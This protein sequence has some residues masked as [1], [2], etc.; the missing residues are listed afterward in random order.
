METNQVE[1]AL[2]ILKYLPPLYNNE[3]SF[4]IDDLTNKDDDFQYL[5]LHNFQTYIYSSRPDIYVIMDKATDQSY[6]PV[7]FS[8]LRQYIIS[9]NAKL[10]PL[11]FH[12]GKSFFYVHNSQEIDFKKMFAIPLLDNL[13][14]AEYVKEMDQR[15]KQIQQDEKDS[16]KMKKQWNDFKVNW[17]G[18]K[19]PSLSELKSSIKEISKISPSRSEKLQA[20]LAEEEKFPGSYSKFVSSKLVSSLQKSIDCSVSELE[21]LWNDQENYGPVVASLIYIGCRSYKLP[22]LA[23]QRFWI[24][25]KNEIRKIADKHKN[26]PVAVFNQYVVQTAC[27]YSSDT[28]NFIVSGYLY[29]K[30]NCE[31]YSMLFFVICHLMQLWYK[32]SS[33]K[34]I[35]VIVPSHIKILFAYV[36]PLKIYEVETTQAKVVLEPIN[37][38]REKIDEIEFA[39]YSE[40]VMGVF[41][42]M[43]SGKRDVN[44]V[45]ILQDVFHNNISKPAQ[46]LLDRSA[47]IGIYLYCQKSEEYW[48]FVQVNNEL[49]LRDLIDVLLST[50][51]GYDELVKRKTYFG[52]DKLK[53][54]EL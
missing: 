37:S 7:S 44:C 14:N 1:L 20:R 22:M 21:K 42:L 18:E 4:T 49:L 2:A 25:M 34:V 16:K 47:V 40:Q 27:Y 50:K 6:F 46:T 10:L 5:A 28:Y 24:E 9:S 36:H 8:T 11:A 45:D 17:L 26:D 38:L 48:N 31:A 30:M 51:P 23:L 3:S 29:G 52:L 19:D 53:D 13:N 35:A 41:A 15:S 39:I 54:V 32:D 33:Y 12:F 43:H